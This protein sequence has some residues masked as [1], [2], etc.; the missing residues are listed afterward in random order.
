MLFSNAVCIRRG[1]GHT[2]VINHREMA[3]SVYNTPWYIVYKA[4]LII[5][6]VRKVMLA[7]SRSTLVIFQCG[8]FPWSKGWTLSNIFN[9]N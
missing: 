3:K 9:Y 2:T 8:S 7:Y 1:G 6:S 4:H 5:S